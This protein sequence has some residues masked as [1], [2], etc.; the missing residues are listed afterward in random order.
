VNHTNNAVVCQGV[1][2][3]KTIICQ[4]NDEFANKLAGIWIHIC[5][6]TEENAK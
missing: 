6:L 2:Q 5:Q 3:V 4:Q 1:C